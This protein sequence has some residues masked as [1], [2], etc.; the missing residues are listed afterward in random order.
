MAE[1]RLIH[2]KPCKTLEEEHRDEYLKSITPYQFQI[3]RALAEEKKEQD[4]LEQ[5]QRAR[6]ARLEME[7]RGKRKN[8]SLSFKGKLKKPFTI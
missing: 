3:E 8:T 6:K 7:E 4:L 1:P 2:V 5:Q